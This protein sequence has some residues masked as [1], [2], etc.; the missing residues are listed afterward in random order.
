MIFFLGFGC[1]HCVDQ[2]LAFSPEYE[3]FLEAGI[4]IVAIGT[5]TVEQL[6]DSQSDR[7]EEDA[8]AFPI[9]SNADLDLF[10]TYRA[11]D[12]FED[13]PLHGTYL[14]D[15]AGHVRWIDISYEPFMDWEFLLEESVRLLGLP[16]PSAVGPVSRI[17][18]APADL[19]GQE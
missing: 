12:D 19:G 4:E 15:G 6:T 17:E 13:T 16:E 10:K 1:V 7:S 3:H 9:L 5:D 11:Y 14:I 18:P 2:L 8:Y